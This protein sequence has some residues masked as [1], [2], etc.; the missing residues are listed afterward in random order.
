MPP[1]QLNNLLHV[2]EHRALPCGPC[3]SVP[4][5]SANP[6]RVCYCW[7]WEVPTPFPVLSSSPDLRSSRGFG[8]SLEAW[9][10]WACDSYSS[11]G[12]S[13]FSGH[14]AVNT[15]RRQACG[16]RGSSAGPQR[17][18]PEARTPRLPC[19]PREEQLRGS[20]E[21]LLVRSL[22]VPGAGAL[23]RRTC[24]GLCGLR[25]HGC[26]RAVPRCGGDGLLACPGPPT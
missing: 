3:H 13:R 18:S 9:R 26:S 15:W 21:P 24:V 7:A 10:F 11:G 16:Q 20:L 6:P 8:P 19:S 25:R 12:N 17:Q 14:G 2:S 23:T 1:G 4:A 5:W 22:R